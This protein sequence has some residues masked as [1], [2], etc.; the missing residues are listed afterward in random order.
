MVERALSG[1][2]LERASMDA[3]ERVPRVRFTPKKSQMM[4]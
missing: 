2:T 3:D 1:H 4:L